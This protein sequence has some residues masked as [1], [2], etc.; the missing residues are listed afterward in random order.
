MITA[1]LAGFDVQAAGEDVA[2]DDWDGFKRHASSRPPDGLWSK[3]WLVTPATVEAMKAAAMKAVPALR[4]VWERPDVE[5]SLM[6]L[7]IWVD[8]DIPAGTLRPV[9][10]RSAR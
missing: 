9:F 8:D 3:G 5:M 10:V 4:P 1:A 6:A 2:I 7:P